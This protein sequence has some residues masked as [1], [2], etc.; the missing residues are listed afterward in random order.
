ML[1]GMRGREWSVCPVLMG[2]ISGD[3]YLLQR[4]YERYDAQTRTRIFTRLVEALSKLLNEKPALL[5]V[6]QHIQGLGLPPSSVHN[7]PDAGYF[8]VG[9]GYMSAAASAGVHTVNSMIGQERAGLG[10]HSGMRQK[11]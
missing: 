5:G 6:G 11:L 4:L 1:H 2:S 8:D 9:L 7:A 3:A 10:Q